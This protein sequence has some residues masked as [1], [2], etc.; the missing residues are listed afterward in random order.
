MSYDVY[1]SLADIMFKYQETDKNDLE[2]ALKFFLDKYF[3][4]DEDE[5]E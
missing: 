3:E 1:N 2:K 4:A 5:N